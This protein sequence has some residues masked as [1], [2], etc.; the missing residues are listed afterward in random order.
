MSD[1]PEKLLV[2][3]IAVPDVWGDD[4]DEA[5]AMYAEPNEPTDKDRL[6]VVLNEWMREDVGVTFVSLPGDKCM[7]SEFNVCAMNGR[8]VG[9]ELRGRDIPGA[10]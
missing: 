3:H 6:E 5:A 4:L 7:N 10:Q 9:A 1:G 8:V 2:L